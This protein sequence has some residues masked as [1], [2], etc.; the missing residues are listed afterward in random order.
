[1]QI[2]HLSWEYPPLVYGGLGRHVHALAEAQAA[3]GHEVVVVTQTEETVADRLVNGVRIITARRDLPQLALTNDTLLAWVAGMEHALTRA[4]VDLAK[5]WRPDVIHAHDWM[6][7]HVASTASRLFDQPFVATFHATEAGRHQGWVPQGL[8]QSVHTVEWW[9]AQAATRLITCSQHMRWEATRLFDVSKDKIDVVPNGIDVSVWKVSPGAAEHAYAQFSDG[10][11]LLVFAGRLEW[12][13]GVQVLLQAFGQ[14][15]LQHPTARLVI[16]GKGGMRERFLQLAGQLRLGHHVR[17][18]GWLP[19]DQLHGLIAGATVAIVPSLYEP[20][21][22][23]ALEAAAL[24]TPL[25]LSEAGGL[26]EIADGGSAAITFTADDSTALAAAIS[27][28][29]A[30]PKEADARSDYASELL[31]RRYAWPI[32]AQETVRSYSRAVADWDAAGPPT[33]SDAPPPLP[34]DNLLLDSVGA[35]A[36]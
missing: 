6:V 25:I 32:I 4:T 18:A 2:L 24:R 26:R 11:P 31:T 20:F 3:Q 23:V 36:R 33:V 7:A 14:T 21:G 12:E 22:L 15:L 34:V 13:K 9:L 28:V 8:P 1:M 30:H 35:S 19:E 10:G 17:F 5:T 16:A 27:E 29:L